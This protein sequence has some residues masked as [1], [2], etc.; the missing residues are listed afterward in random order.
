MNEISFT[1][2]ELTRHVEIQV[3]AFMAQAGNSKNR[4]EREA[5]EN[6]AKGVMMAWASLVYKP[7]VAMGDAAHAA[8]N[9]DYARMLDSVGLCELAADMRTSGIR[10]AWEQALDV[11][12]RVQSN[13][14][15]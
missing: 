11:I 7:V 15:K 5:F 13:G 14:Q 8:H 12:D 10:W 1:Y 3:G 6:R 4:R 9:D 2:S